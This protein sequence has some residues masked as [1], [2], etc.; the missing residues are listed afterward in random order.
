MEDRFNKETEDKS[1]DW[2]PV[3]KSWDEFRKT[4]LF[5][6][7]NQFLHIFGWALTYERDNEQTRVYPARVRYRGFDESAQT[8]AYEKVQKYMVENAKTLYEES[9]YDERE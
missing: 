1:D 6:I 5:V 3:E 4:G 2:Y 8:R 9:D 7:V